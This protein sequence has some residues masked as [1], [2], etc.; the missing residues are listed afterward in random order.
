[1]ARRV[2]PHDNTRVQPVSRRAAHAVV[3]QDLHEHVLPGIGGDVRI[4]LLYL[5]R[6]LSGRHAQHLV[7]VE[8]DHAVP[9][10]TRGGV[11]DVGAL[12]AKSSGTF[13]T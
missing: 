4:V 12:K 9:G 13:D 6:G 1:M 8:E 10:R 7:A 2:L 3:R 5:V 11:D